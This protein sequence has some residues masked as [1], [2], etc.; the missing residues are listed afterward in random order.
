[1]ETDHHAMYTHAPTGAQSEQL[2][3]VRPFVHFD[4]A[5]EE[6]TSLSLPMTY[7]SIPFK[8]FLLYQPS[9]YRQ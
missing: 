8:F 2:L 3:L 6:D 9:L 4:P 7:Q 1:M 5:G